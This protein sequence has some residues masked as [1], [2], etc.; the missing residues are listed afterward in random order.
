MYLKQFEI[1]AFCIKTYCIAEVYVTKNTSC[2][3]KIILLTKVITEQGRKMCFFVRCINSVKL[4][5]VN[6]IE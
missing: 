4:F 2:K 1:T 3:T 6:T 5:Q